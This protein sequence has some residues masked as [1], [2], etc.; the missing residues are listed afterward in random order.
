MKVIDASD[1]IAGRLSA[2]VARML[3]KGEQVRVINAEKAVISGNPEYLEKVYKDRMW[4]GDPY[5]GPFFPK[6]PDRILKRMVRG[7][8]PYKKPMGR[9]ALKRLKVY[10]SVPEELKSQEAQKIKGTENRLECKFTSLG[11]ISLKIGG[12]K[13]W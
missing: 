9:D 4:R 6:Q 5:H 13:R 2:E 10:I 11:D 1:A 12:K 7:M 8:L 3:L